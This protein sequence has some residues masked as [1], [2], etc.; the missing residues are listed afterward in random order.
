MRKWS[1]YIYFSQCFIM[2]NDKFSE[3]TSSV[4]YFV[5]IIVVH[6]NFKTYS[7]TQVNPFFPLSS[8]SQGS[9]FISQVQ[10]FPIGLGK[11]YP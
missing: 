8:R 6:N 4:M 10:V 5:G 3:Y 7:Q 9:K 2:L 1:K 11:K